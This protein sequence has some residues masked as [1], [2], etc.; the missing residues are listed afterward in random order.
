MVHF[1]HPLDEQ[2]EALEPVLE[3]RGVDDVLEVS[4]ETLEQGAREGLA[5]EALESRYAEVETTIREAMDTTEASLLQD[6]AF[7]SR[8][9]RALITASLYEYAE[10]VDEGDFTNVVEYQDG[11]GMMQVGRRMLERQGEIFGATEDA[12]GYQ[13]LLDAYN[14]ALRAWPSAEAPAEPVMSFGELSG[15][16]FRLENLLGDY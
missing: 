4:L 6:P 12:E 9:H 15:A 11:R 14:E 2:Y 3:S 16:V 8:V 10:A 13:A 1:A 5:W 7:V